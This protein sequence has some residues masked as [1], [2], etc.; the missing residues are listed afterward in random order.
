MKQHLLVLERSRLVDNLQ[1]AGLSCIGVPKLG[2][3]DDARD[4][5]WHGEAEDACD[6]PKE[7]HSTD[8]G[9]GYCEQVGDELHL[10]CCVV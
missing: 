6:S 4:F 8:A 3:P 1:L 7:I 9:V 2:L 10:E 5:L